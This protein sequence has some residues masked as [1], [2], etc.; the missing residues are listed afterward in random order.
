MAFKYVDIV[1]E[2]EAKA[3]SRIDYIR[4]ESNIMKLHY[5]IAGYLK[6]PDEE[7]CKLLETSEIEDRLKKLIK[8]LED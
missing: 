2:S 6:V 4:S 5:I 7:K 8:I 1:T 3:R